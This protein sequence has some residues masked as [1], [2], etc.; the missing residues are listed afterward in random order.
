MKIQEQSNLPL[1]N[2]ISTQNI[3]VCDLEKLS[4]IALSQNLIDAAYAKKVSYYR[5]QV[6]YSPKVFIPLTFLCRDVCHYCTFAQT[7]KKVK[8]PYLS[9]EEVISIAK[10]GEVQGCHE[11]LFTLGDKPELRY[12]AARDALKLMG[13]KTTN[14]YLGAC[15]K[16]VLDNTSL[17][18]HLNSGCLTKDEITSLKPLSGSMG[19]MVESL[20]SKLTEKGQPHHGSPDKDPEFRIKTLIEAGKQKVPFTTG[21]L[22]G[23]GETRLE[24][25]ESLFEIA[26]LHK[27]YNHIQEVIVQNFK[28]KSNT[29]MAHSPEPSFDELLWTIAMARLILPADISLQVPPNLN[30]KYLDRLF[31]S[32]INDLGGIS[33]VTKDY[34]NPEAPWPEIQN[35]AKIAFK[36]NQSLK[37]RATLY[38]KYFSALS[39]FSSREIAS[40]LLD[41]V[42]AQFLIRSDN[43]QSGISTEIPQINFGIFCSD[44]KQQIQQVE[45]NPSIESIQRLLESSDGDFQ[46][47]I[48]RANEIK[49]NTHGSDV[50]FVVNRNI[51]YT[52]ICSF[53]CNFCAF[54]K[55]R[56]HDDLRGKPYNISHTEII[57]RT[58][59]AIQRGATEVC[60]QGGIHPNYSGQTYID[61]VKAI[62]SSSQTIHI[63]AF[64]PLEIDHGRKTLGI[65]TYEFLFE[66]KKAGLNSLPGTAA[67][68]LHDDVRAVICPDKLS[69]N[70]WLEII[71]TAHEVGLPTTSTMMFGHVENMSHVADHLLKLLQLQSETNGITEFVPL[72]FVAEEAP[73]YRRGM[74]RPGPTFK[75]TILVHAVSRI[76]FN[77]SIDN[78]Q[79]SWVKMGLP[80]L[81]FLLSSGINDVGGILMNESITKS[82]GASFGQELSLKNVLEVT[83]ELELNLVQR[84]TLYHP[85]N[86]THDIKNL[87]QS[88]TIPLLPIK[89]E[90]HKPI[91]TLINYEN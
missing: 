55:G 74:A 82:A 46:Y 49:V 38:P 43:W 21:I 80:G 4:N 28:P 19:L 51:N 40:K 11:A 57:R 53:S 23:I 64:S 6:T 84:N 5:D 1:K 26:E 12:K 75:E 41:K 73:I 91:K 13:Y 27:K 35:L 59:E 69:S 36:S 67:E 88:Q 15:A 50:S 2:L 24:R 68:I 30:L 8:S 56:G 81:K 61:I 31:T 70:E 45:I 87:I 39:E 7:P 71:K 54:S 42:D 9:I 47:I 32:G 18:P 29:L 37:S 60:L 62:R 72:P 58:E 33:P 48:D 77:N 90:Y 83:D 34:V 44:I 25:L 22:I 79:G 52:N 66:L 65:S 16:A 89:N 78:I 76:L 10:E 20:S 3:D 14:E 85:I 17:M 63:H 86:R